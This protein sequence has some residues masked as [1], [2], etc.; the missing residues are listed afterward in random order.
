MATLEN[1]ESLQD[2]AFTMIKEF[3]AKIKN[4][5]EK[6]E[7]SIIQM[8]RFDETILDKASKYDVVALNKKLER[9]LIKS[10]FDVHLQ[11][12]ENFS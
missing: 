6:I 1:L 2:K 10:E 3:V 8:V 12:Y 5:D 7:N 4:F 9:C 11:H